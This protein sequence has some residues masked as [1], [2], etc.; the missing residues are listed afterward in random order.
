MT[1]M[2]TSV[3]SRSPDAG[4]A[5]GWPSGRPA[6]RALAR[7]SATS[8][9]LGLMGTSAFVAVF[10]RLLEAWR[11][12]PQAASHHVTIL[13]QRLGYPAANAGA[14]VVLGLALLGAVVAGIAISAI[15][16]EVRG[17]RR[18]AADLGRRHPVARDGA[19]VIDDPR[20]GAFSAGLLRPRVYV[21]SGARA[22]L[23]AAE[24]DAVVAHERHHALRRDPLR[25]AA[26][27]VL[28][29]SLFF[30][31]GL[32]ELRARHLALVEASADEA[33]VI[34]SGGDRSAL[35]RAMLRFDEGASGI[36]PVR[37][38]YLLG[39]TPSW[40]LPV[41]LCL[42][43]G[44]LLALVGAAAVLAGREAAGSASLAPPF[45]SA[46][47]CIVMLALIPAGAGLLGAALRRRW[48]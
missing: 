14:V 20:L 13:G 42:A 48:S 1:P 2:T 27:R 4:L 33:A 11:V 31:P 45:L 16:R 32:A 23:D 43:A 12:S 28:A 15:A 8:V 5:V 40:R 34:Q 25:L 37:V 29:R 44:A 41:V 30:L 3:N 24:L 7:V 21:T 9:L 35:A 10:V 39:E 36:D 47:P 22:V 19:W 6:T 46:Q 17:A 18:L 38:D 26:G